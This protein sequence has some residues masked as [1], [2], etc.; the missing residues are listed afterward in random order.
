MIGCLYVFLVDLYRNEAHQHNNF[1]LNGM[2]FPLKVEFSLKKYVIVGN[3]RFYADGRIDVD[4]PQYFNTAVKHFET[5]LSRMKSTLPVIRKL[6]EKK[7]KYTSDLSEY[8]YLK[9]KLGK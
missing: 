9:S 5:L 2:I 4:P 7:E 6:R 3:T 1:P 8:E